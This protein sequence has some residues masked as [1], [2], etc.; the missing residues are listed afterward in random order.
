MPVE[1]LVRLLLLGLLAGALGGLVG[2]GGSIVIIPVLTLLLNK[3]QHLSQA[4]AMI[5]NVLVA[6]ASLLQHH[7]AVR[8]IH[9]A[10]IQFRPNHGS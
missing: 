7:R 2:V 1:E 8:S 6:A 10:I 5:I 3:D 9:R 4:T